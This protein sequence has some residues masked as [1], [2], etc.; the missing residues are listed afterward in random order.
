MFLKRCT[1]KKNGK[2][3]VYWQLVESY[4]TARG[5]R[6]RVVSYLGELSVG[7]RRGWGRLAVALDGKA[8]VKAKQLSLF[9]PGDDGEPVPDRIE[10]DRHVL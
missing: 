7:E 5:S 3:H 1:R 6:H 2:Q 10:V 8:S 9:E 4:R